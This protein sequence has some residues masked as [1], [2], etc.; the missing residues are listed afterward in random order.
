MQSDEMMD[1]D[2]TIS[3]SM[4]CGHRGAA[5]RFPENTF[6]AF[7]AAREM[8]AGWVETDIQMLADGELVL[9]H[10]EK[11]GRTSEGEA[12]LSTLTWP[13]VQYLDMGTWKA[14]EFRGET[15]VRMADLLAW[16]QTVANT[17]SVIWEMKL[18]LD[19]P[20]SRVKEAA[21]RVA[22]LLSG[23]SS[24]RHVLTSFHRRFIKAVRHLVPDVPMAL[25]SVEFPNDWLTF[26]QQHQLQGVRQVE[27]HARISSKGWLTQAVGLESDRGPV[28]IQDLPEQR[29][30]QCGPLEVAV[31]ID[32]SPKALPAFDFLSGEQGLG[33]R[34]HATMGLSRRSTSTVIGGWTDRWRDQA[35]RQAA[36]PS[37]AVQRTGCRSAGVAAGKGG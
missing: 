23:V 35:C 25:A 4:I 33:H 8:G 13:E 30:E 37:F 3:P 16:Q 14:P 34:N 28:S 36:R 19:D 1:V 17:P 27:L 12:I 15:L 6:A 20:L 32:R 29:A 18:S 7:K 10:D 21:D 2:M 11:L 31:T 5:E 9:F 24:D 26:C 22:K